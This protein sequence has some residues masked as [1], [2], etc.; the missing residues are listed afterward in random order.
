MDEQP[1]RRPEMEQHSTADYAT[2]K[3]PEKNK[4]LKKPKLSFNWRKPLKYLIILAVLGAVAAGVYWFTT[5]PDTSP[6]VA[7][8][9]KAETSQSSVAEES[10]ITAATKHYS[11]ADFRLEFDHPTDWKVTDTSGSGKLTV[12]SPDIQLT[13]QDGK[14]VTGQIT[15][16]IRDKRQALPEFDKGNSIAAR[17]SEK[18]AYTKPSQNQRASTYISFLR[19]AS[20]AQAQGDFDGIYITGDTGY[21]KDQA[22]PKADFTPVDPVISVTFSKDNKQLTV[23]DNVWDDPD[24]LKP[25]KA[26]LQSLTIN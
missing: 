19:Y 12:V 25:I 6:S 26:M 1:E 21:Q 8:N 24:Y 18:V 4:R 20:S 16:T 5:K 17:E 11:S 14:K 7:D 3:K 9:K 23:S 15:M 22:I 13:D 10:K 2:F